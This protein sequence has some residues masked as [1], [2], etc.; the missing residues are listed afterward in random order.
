MVDDW[1]DIW[2]SEHQGV[3]DTGKKTQAM[4]CSQ[5]VLMLLYYSSWP[6][7][8]VSAMPDAS[9]KQLEIRAHLGYYLRNIRNIGAGVV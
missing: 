2:I 6:Y 1:S 8:N 3:R 9:P 5:E 4:A 7:R